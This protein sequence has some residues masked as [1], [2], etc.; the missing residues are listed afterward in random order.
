MRLAIG[1]AC[2]AKLVQS[3]W[4]TLGALL[5]LLPSYSKISDEAYVAQV[6]SIANVAERTARR[7]LRKLEQLGILGYESRRGRGR[8]PLISLPSSPS[9]TGQ[10]EGQSEKSGQYLGQSRVGRPASAGSD[11]WP[12]RGPASEKDRED[13]VVVLIDQLGFTPTQRARA[14]AEDPARVLAWLKRAQEPDV[15]NAAAFAD[16][17]IA[18][19]GWPGFQA[20]EV[21][22]SHGFSVRPADEVP[23]GPW[24][25]Y[26][27]N[28]AGDALNLVGTF[29][30]LDEARR[31]YDEYDAK[32]GAAMKVVGA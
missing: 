7:S 1:K 2:A 28:G 18:A 3:D 30:D 24:E 20:R 22:G 16:A 29:D 6:A 11:D 14:L 25:V 19:G 32:G 31:V 26:G 10:H 21:R 23:S 5:V 27:L 4:R 8:A 9:L 12:H 17:G 13:D 15:K